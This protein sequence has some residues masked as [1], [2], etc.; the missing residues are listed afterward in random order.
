MDKASVGS[1]QCA[2]LTKPLT[3]GTDCSPR[4]W[5]PASGCLRASRES[6]ARRLHGTRTT[7]L[8]ARN[9]PAP[10]SRIRGKQQSSSRYRDVANLRDLP[11]GASVSWRR[12]QTR[13]GH[14]EE[15]RTTLHLAA[16][17]TAAGTFD[18]WPT[19][20]VEPF[21]SLINDIEKHIFRSSA[22]AGYWS[23]ATIVTTPADQ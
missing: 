8:P 12:R 15:Q 19:R 10:R 23:N 14:G 7:R 9:Q 20:D 11:S 17:R 3:I 4:C 2:G 22:P 5:T 6:P 1:K 13:E 16:Q 18:Y 21:D